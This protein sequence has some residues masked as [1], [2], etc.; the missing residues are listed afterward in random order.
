[1]GVN[2]TEMLKMLE[3][4]L[5]FS[6]EIMTVQPTS[7]T[8]VANQISMYVFLFIF[9]LFCVLLCFQ[10]KHFK[11][12]DSQ[13]TL[14]VVYVMNQFCGSQVTVVCVKFQNGLH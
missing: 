14:V 1:M 12:T 4:L 7:D 8:S 6:I 10:L 9:Y 5:F 13:L 2:V 3:N 11:A